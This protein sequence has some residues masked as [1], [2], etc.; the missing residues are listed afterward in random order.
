MTLTAERGDRFAR[1]ALTPVIAGE[2]GAVVWVGLV[3]EVEAAEREGRVPRGEPYP[4]EKVRAIGGPLGEDQQGEPLTGAE[5]AAYRAKNPKPV[6][7]A[8][9]NRRLDRDVR[10]SKEANAREA[11]EKEALRQRFRPAPTSRADRSPAD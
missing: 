9:E 7:T 8:A 5:L 6:R 2:D 11:V 4:A 3:G 1:E 10:L